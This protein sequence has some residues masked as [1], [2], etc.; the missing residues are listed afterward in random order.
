M[1][2]KTMI[3]LFFTFCLTFAALALSV[4]ADTALELTV[5]ASGGDYTTVES[6]LAAVETMAKKGELNAKGVHLILSGSHTATAKD[7]ILFGQKTIF[8]YT[9]KKL[10]ITISGGTLTLPTGNVACTN[11]YTFTDIS[12]PFDDIATKL[13][14]GSGNVT[15][16]N[17]TLDLNGTAQ[18]KS[19]FYADTFTGKVFEGWTEQNLNG[20]MK[21]GLF[22]SSMTLGEGFNYE[23]A[24]TYAFASVGSSTDFTAVIG[25]KTL[26]ADDT[27]TELIVDG[28]TL[29]NT[30]SRVG[31]NPVGNSVL[32]IKSGAV[33]HLYATPSS[34]NGVTHTG[35]ITVL[36][37]GGS[38]RH[39]VRILN[40]TTLNGN[41]SVFLKNMDL[42]QNNPTDDGQM[43]EI[44]FAGVTVKGNVTVY[45][46]NVKAD[47][48]YGAMGGKGYKVTG[49]VSTTVKNCDFTRFFYGGFGQSAVYGNVENTLENVNIGPRF[50]GLDECPTL[51]NKEE[52]TG[53]KSSVGNLTNHLKNVT[54]AEP[55]KEDTIHLGASVSCEVAG[56]ITNTLENVTVQG[57]LSLYC[58][59]QGGT[60]NGNITNTVKSG[61]FSHYL[62]GGPYSGTV[63]GTLLNYVQGGTYLQEVY[64]GGYMP[65]VTGKIEN[66]ISGGNFDTLYLFCGTRNGKVSNASIPY[67]IENYF[68]GGSFKGVWGG[69]GNGRDSV[70]T[71]NV[72][73]E[74]SGGH[75]GVYNY[76]D[77]INSFAGSVRNG[78]HNAN[79]DTLIRGGVFEGYVYGGAIPN[80]ADWGHT[81]KGVSTLTLAGGEFRYIIGADSRWGAFEESHL[82][83]NTEKALEPLSFGYDLECESFI[84]AHSSAP[85][86]QTMTVTCKELIARGTG[87]LQVFGTVICDV[88][89]VE[90]NAAVPEIYG[91]VKAKS[92]LSGGKKLTL[93][94]KG[95][96][97]VEQTDGTVNLYQSE[98]WLPRTYFTSPAGTDITLSMAESA[99]GEA[100]AVNGVVKGTSSAFAGVSFVFD[101]KISLRFFFDKA[102]VENE[103]DLFLFNAV[104][105]DRS[106]AE[107]VRFDDLVLKNGYYTVQS[108][109]LSATEL[110]ATVIVSGNMMESRSFTLLQLAETGIH[111][112]GK[113]SQNKELGELLKAFSN[114]AVATDNYKN[115]KNTPLPYE[116]AT[117]ET[118]FVGQKGFVPIV[119]TPLVQLQ[120]KQL[121][122]DDGMRIR[123][124]L[125]SDE[126]NTT[127]KNSSPVNSLHYF[128]NCV[129]VTNSVKK[130]WV[131][132]SSR[133]GYFEITVDLPVTPS[134][135]D[136]RIRFIV[137]E[138]D[139]L[140]T[141][142][143]ADSTEPYTTYVSEDYIDRLDSIAEELAGTAGSEELGAA[144]LYYLQAGAAYYETQPDISDF[145]YP[146]EFSAGFGREDF[147]PYGYDM[148]MYSGRN[149]KVVLDPMYVTCLALWDGDE[150]ALI[151]SLDF[152]GVSAD[153]AKKYKNVL[154][155]ELRGLIDPDKIFFNA[156][157]DHSGPN[158]SS[159]NSATVKVWYE[160]I[161]DDALMMATKKAILDLAPSRLYTGS[162]L[163][164]PGTNY[165]RRYV[166]AD[167]TVTGIHNIIPASNVV[168]YET[169]ADK[170]L[171]TMRFEREGKTDIVYVNWQGHVAHG[172]AYRYQFTADLVNWLRSGVEEDMGV[173]FIYCNG[174]SGNINFTPKVQADIDAKYFTSPYFSQIGTSLVGTVKKAVATEKQIE[175]DA[176]KVTYIPFLASVKHEDEDTV[177]RAKEA[178]ELLKAYKAEH[179]TD[180][181]AK[182][183][184]TQTGFQSKYEISH[185]ITRSGMGETNTIGLYAFSFGDAAMSFVPFEQFDTNAMQIRDGVEDLYEITFTAAYSNGSHSYIPSAY[186]APHGGYEVY[187]SR[188]VD[189]TGDDIAFAL[190][191][192][193]RAMKNN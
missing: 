60:V 145:T 31:F 161:F 22:Y 91:T 99:S 159:M 113:D 10:P 162:A 57:K 52:Y 164:D 115:G 19:Y 187:S 160:T 191:E 140:H 170:E 21:N 124:Y 50:R 104:C 182:Q 81:H 117:A 142:L 94:A 15:L 2:K 149:G 1:M 6:A 127:M 106:L 158:A 167:G 51:G 122:L 172:A 30:M 62:Y 132:S 9:G 73:N 119:N 193:L 188:Y 147:S 150:L 71:A 55:A 110:C 101:D 66:H 136:D 45:M 186:A 87:A 103:K 93:G 79:V 95:T 38:I 8:L 165:V 151:Y 86:V 183:I 33:N 43:I 98:Y 100:T 144:L 68:T 168:A 56:D 7:G 190:V 139:D 111:L 41:L 74:I 112:Y 85:S 16:K 27:R 143:P 166:N 125:K 58:A 116:N 49:D 184:Q 109:Y 46:E 123:Y 82:Y 189:S 97:T 153:F 83:V 42:T 92:L 59:N 174:A 32:Q 163:S 181:P 88:F 137:A 34:T 35:S 28:A 64:L 105:G 134:K 171:R 148:D 141:A 4:Q 89:T 131:A 138:K 24:S 12:I 128:Y 23:S 155:N 121:V 40:K 133:K 61:T 65:T 3:A 39:F 156:T 102:S 44:G 107:N 169:E 36:V 37:E 177:T 18:Y 152:R 157:H 146:T 14:A 53:S 175:T 84:A 70:L 90:T 13:Y 76:Q 11:D 72:Y 173:H 20:Y 178:N 63:K 25:S 120:N 180:M 17:I 75:F 48:Y 179:G 47:R 80:Q 78:T 54:F 5:A 192:A 185:I 154:K 26:S 108:D 130:T 77:K 67:P 118:G 135:S 176:F 126:M 29:A 69:G 129:D 96:L 114:Y